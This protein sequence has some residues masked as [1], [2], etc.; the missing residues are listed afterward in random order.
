M[1]RAAAA[2]NQ[3]WQSHWVTIT[4]FAVLLAFTR[5]APRLPKNAN[6]AQWSGFAA[7]T[8]LSV[9]LAF[10]LSTLIHYLVRGAYRTLVRK[11]E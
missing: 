2:V 1:E 9:I 7:E 10:A 4:F 5:I 11:H 6:A 3:L 8:F